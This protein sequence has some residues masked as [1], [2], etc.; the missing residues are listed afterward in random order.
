MV[1]GEPIREQLQQKDQD[2]EENCSTE[3]CEPIE[4]EYGRHYE[5][6]SPGP[7][8]PNQG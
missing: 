1:L 4:H 3:D 7:H 2:C 8:G 5:Y 6:L